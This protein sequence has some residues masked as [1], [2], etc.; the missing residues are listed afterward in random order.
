MDARSDSGGYVQ[1][2]GR[3]CVACSAKIV[4]S[5]DGK[6][7]ELCKAFLHLGCAEGHQCNDKVV[8]QF[9]SKAPS[10]MEMAE[11]KC[12]FCAEWI[13]AEAIKC[14]YCLTALP[15]PCEVTTGSK[16][17]ANPSCA[18]SPETPPPDRR[19]NQP[20]TQE[21]PVH[22]PRCRSTQVSAQSKGFGL[23]KAAVGGLLIG[24]VGLLGGLVGSRKVRLHCLKCAHCW[25]PSTG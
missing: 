5:I 23:G 20:V 9:G 4:A 21:P 15:L 24:P 7:C 14:R 18:T 22:C 10:S 3:T 17:V 6:R 2:T 12:P 1:V 13:K 16:Q 11:K 19:E 8:T 25:I